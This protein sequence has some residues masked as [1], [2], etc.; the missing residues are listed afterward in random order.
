MENEQHR[1]AVLLVVLQI[2]TVEKGM[3]ECNTS[4]SIKN[5]PNL[6][7]SCFTRCCNFKLF[8][9]ICKYTPLY[10]FSIEMQSAETLKRLS[11]LIPEQKEGAFEFMYLRRL[12]NSDTMGPFLFTSKRDS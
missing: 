1:T 4:G 7:F 12:Y 6:L 2:N 8:T 3:K 11:A 10:T 9:N 5:F